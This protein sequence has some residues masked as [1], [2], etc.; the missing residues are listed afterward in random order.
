MSRRRP[1]AKSPSPPDTPQSGKGP[2]P[3]RRWLPI[4]AVAALLTAGGLWWKSRTPDT[5]TPIWNVEVIGSYPHDPLAFTQGL[6][7]DDGAILEG[8]GKYGSSELRRVELATGSIQKRHPL[9]KE[10][11]GEGITIADKN[12]YQL[13]WKQGIA[14][15]YHRSDWKEADRLRYEG[16]GWGIT[17]DGTH[18]ITSDGSSTLRFRRTSDLH[19][20]REIKVRDERFP[21]SKLN[22][23]EFVRGRIYANVW[24][25]DRIA[26]IDPESGKVE[27]WID[28][29]QL[30]PDRPSD[31]VL[32]GI[33]Y[34]STGD[35]LFVTGKNWP[36]LYEIKLLR[37]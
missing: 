6:T 26:V 10:F 8:T 21:I 22:E 24:Y 32:N 4:V 3:L 16:Q 37:P 7:W 1:P 35:R 19:V 34:D 17:F 14:F 29:S 13:T 20:V 18:L 28:L 5:K 36:K 12:I 15:V 33:A 9:A 31:K 2:A 25:R 27:A 30:W 23:L 11:F